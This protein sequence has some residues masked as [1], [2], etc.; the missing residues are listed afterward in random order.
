MA[1][2]TQIQ[3][4]LSNYIDT[5]IVPSMSGWQKWVFG[6][7]VAVAIGNLPA[8]INRWKD[9][10][11]VKLL[12]VIDESGNIDVPKIYQGVKR[13]SAKGPVSFNVPGMGTLTLHDAD[14]DKIYNMIMGG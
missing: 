2:I 1:S 7:G 6:A 10:E 13:Q 14:V 9:T 4:G 11:I 8:T 5:E 12:G 3:S